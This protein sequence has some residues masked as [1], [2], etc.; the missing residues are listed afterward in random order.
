[1]AFSPNDKFLAIGCVNSVVRIYTVASWKQTHEFRKHRFSVRRVEWHPDP[2]KL[3][4]LTLD[5]ESNF[6]IFDYMLNQVVHSVPNFGK[7]FVLTESGK[8]IIS[9]DKDIRVWDYKTCSLQHE[10]KLERHR[11]DFCLV[12]KRHHSA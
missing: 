6:N 2:N 7:N 11:Q 3:Q 10:Y 5:E 9:C 4:L 12:V 1:M 8:T